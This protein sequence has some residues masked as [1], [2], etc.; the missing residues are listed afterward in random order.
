MLQSVEYLDT[1]QGGNLPP[2]KESVHFCLTFR[3]PDR[4]LTGEE[5][6]H[7]VKAVVDA[8]VAKFH[9]KLRT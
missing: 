2:D 4:T 5:V 6:D 9:A 8:C 3:H 1:F 7:A